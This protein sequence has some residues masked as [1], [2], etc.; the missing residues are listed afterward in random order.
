MQIRFVDF[1]A[2]LDPDGPRMFG[3]WHGVDDFFHLPGFLCVHLRE[4]WDSWDSFACDHAADCGDDMPHPLAPVAEDLK[5]LCPA[6]VLG[7]S[8]ER[9]GVEWKSLAGGPVEGAWMGGLR[10][11]VGPHVAFGED[12]SGGDAYGW[13]VAS[14]PDIGRNIVAADTAPTVDLAKVAAVDAAK[15]VGRGG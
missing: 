4:A 2:Q 3:F 11:R 13:Q 8:G 7:E 12:E 14:G 5:G 10:L 6:W 1:G 9:E 15:G